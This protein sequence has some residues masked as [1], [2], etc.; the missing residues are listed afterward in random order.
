[1]HAVVRGRGGGRSTGGSGGGGRVLWHVAPTLE[2]AQDSLR[3]PR[4]RPPAHSGGSAAKA[5][6]ASLYQVSD[7]LGCSQRC[8]ISWRASRWVSSPAATASLRC[9]SCARMTSSAVSPRCSRSQGPP[10]CRQVMVFIGSSFRG[11]DAVPCATRAA[12]P[13]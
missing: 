7:C 8:F 10:S 1:R 9:S 5:A 2:R 13:V 12:V 4:G 6:L 11:G 3:R